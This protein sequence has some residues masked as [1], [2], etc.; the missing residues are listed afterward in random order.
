MTDLFPTVRDLARSGYIFRIQD[1]GRTAD[2]ITVAFCDGDYL[3]L[4]WPSGSGFSQWGEGLDPAHME[5]AAEN[6]EAVDLALGDLTPELRAHILRR[7]NEAWR[8]F[9]EAANAPHGR[10]SVPENE[11]THDAAGVG[12]YRDGNEFFRVRRE[13]EQ[14]EDPSRPTFREAVL[15]TLPEDY[16]LSGPEYH[17]AINP[18]SL[19]RTKGVRAA[20]RALEAKEADQ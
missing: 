9:L 6:G 5:E 15:Y 16:A 13:G 7:V 8:D 18:G 14:N 12:I 10:L 19:R 3:A 1:E 4:S 11:G 20:V 2:R 17:P